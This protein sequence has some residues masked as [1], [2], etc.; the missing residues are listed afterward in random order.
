M[1]HRNLYRRQSIKALL[2]YDAA[3]SLP[4]SIRACGHTVVDNKLIASISS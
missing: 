1:N 4:W 3:D 2:A